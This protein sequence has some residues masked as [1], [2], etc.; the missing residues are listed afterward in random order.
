M[1]YNELY[2]LVQDYVENDEATYLANLPDMVRRVE[3]RICEV[4]NVPAMIQNSTSTT[5]GS[6]QYLGMPLDFLYPISMNVISS[7]T[8][9]PVMEKEADFIREA[10]PSITSTGRPRYYAQFSESTFLLGPTP[11]QSYTVE[12]HYGRYPDSMVDTPSTETWISRNCE[13]ALLW[14]TVV[15]SALYEKLEQDTLTAYQNRFMEAL[16]Q[17]KVLYSGRRRK[18]QYRAPDVRIDV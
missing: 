11:D 8:F 17:L 13:D 15:E 4:I 14:G 2:E 1:T 5:T 10:F 7:N 12:L 16:E 18:D 6:N 3:R 9:Y